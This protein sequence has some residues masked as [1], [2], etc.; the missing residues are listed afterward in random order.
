MNAS[1]K[2]TEIAKIKEILNSIHESDSWKH[3][4]TLSHSEGT[5]VIALWHESLSGQLTPEKF[6]SYSPLSGRILTEKGLWQ[7]DFFIKKDSS[8]IKVESL[9]INIILRPSFSTLMPNVLH[10]ATAVFTNV[11]IFFD[12]NDYFIDGFFRNYKI[13]T[14]Q[15]AMWT[16]IKELAVSEE[17]NPEI[18]DFIF[19]ETRSKE[20]TPQKYCDTT[21]FHVELI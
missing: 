12:G 21:I 13:N 4:V 1:S 19:I 9:I 10:G 5:K 2:L 15:K 7:S 6:I 11:E 3:S 8:T 16:N 14:P 17:I 20:V 18:E